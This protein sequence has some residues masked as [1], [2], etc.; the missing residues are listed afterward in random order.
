MFKNSLY[1]ILLCVGVLTLLTAAVQAQATAEWRLVQTSY[2]ATDPDGAGPAT[3]TVQF[4]LEMHAI[5]GSFVATDISTGFS[6]QSTRAMLPTTSAC[7][8]NSSNIVLSPAFVAAGYSYTT[9]NQCNM[10][11]FSAGG[12]NLDRIVSGS[13]DPGSSSITINTTWTPVFTVTLWAL[14][15]TLPQAGFAAVHSSGTGTPGPLGS[16]S[17]AD[18]V[19]NEIVVNS[20]S[21]D[22]P[23]PLGSGTLPVLLTNFNVQ[24][25]P[26]KSTSVS[27]TT[28]QEINNN[29]FEVE[30]SANGI[31]WSTLDKVPGSGNSSIQKNY[32][33]NDAQGGAAFYRLKQV[34]IDGKITYS[35][36]ARASCEGRNVL[37]TLFP[38]PARDI[39]TLVVSADRS[40]KTALMVFDSKG[41][42]VV[43]MAVTITTGTNNF[44]IPV[45]KLAAGEYIIR[46]SEPGIEI[47]KRFTVVR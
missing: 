14:G 25:Q 46:S 17:I 26:N 10:V 44:K 12:Q 16:Y 15:S 24:C 11:N 18:N 32:Q 40:I 35:N 36:N 28:S 42:L 4:R 21:F 2:S 33:I 19:G 34:D 20:L 41:R 5:A 45:Q 22:T 23:L 6:W 27:W 3:G 9:V 13:L 31:T 8:G 38:V 7:T 43:N 29:Y 30:K 39:V 1:K 37:A 47:S